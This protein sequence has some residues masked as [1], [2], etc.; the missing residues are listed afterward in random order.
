MISQFPLRRWAILLPAALAG[1]CAAPVE[2]PE[3]LAVL[4][5]QESAWNRGDLDAFMQGYWESGELSFT[6]PDGKFKGWRETRDRYRKSYPDA[7]AMGRLRFDRLAVSRA[8]DDSASVSGKY[9]VDTPDGVKS[10]R[11]FLRLRRLDGRW[12]I[13]S[14]HTVPDVNPPR[15]P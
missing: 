5:E 11:F 14:D 12:R 1:G 4:R 8:G 13:I 9:R 7:A 3:I 2:H 10:G 6:T 15:G